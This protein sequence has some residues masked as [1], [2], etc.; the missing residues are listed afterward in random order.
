MSLKIS[1]TTKPELK[2]SNG[3][4]WYE[5]YENGIRNIELH[6]DGILS[7]EETATFKA[8]FLGSEGWRAKSKYESPYEILIQEDCNVYG[9]KEEGV[10]D[11]FD[12]KTREEDLADRLFLVFRKHAIP[13]DLCISAR[14]GLRGAARPSKNRGVAGGK[15]DVSRF[16]RKAK[17]TV[18]EGDS[19]RSIAEAH[20][21]TCDTLLDLNS[22][23]GEGELKPGDVIIVPD[24]GRVISVGDGT[25]AKYVSKDG[26]VSD[27]VEANMTMGGIAGY[28]PP[29]ARNPY[30]R[31]TAYTRD[32][33][34]LFQK[35]WPFLQEM[36]RYYRMM[37]P[38][39]Y[40]NQ[41]R[42]IEEH[43]LAE[44]GWVIP[45]TVFSTIT[46]NKNFQT[47][48]HQDKGDFKAGME[49]FAV[50]EDGVDEYD[51]GYT[52]FPKFRTA[53]DARTG[54]FVCMDVAHHWHGNV[55][56]V[57]RV[58]GKGDWE[59]ISLVLYV[60]EDMAGA[61]TQEQERAKYEAWREKHRNPTEQHEFRKEV[62]EK[63][64]AD[65]E[66]MGYDGR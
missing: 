59:R 27:T 51:G 6:G 35:S 56:M 10:F 7:D 60:R 21:T 2:E 26:I 57:D 30:V 43:H 33:W 16:G 4:K 11:L 41:Q 25:R 12:T 23:E 42:F 24:S 32:N 36:T 19:L 14:E 64:A 49:C 62:R 61:G 52:C 65:W 9:P 29:T 37:S 5:W 63:N 48:C 3:L 13:A 58:E 1:R 17:Y 47:A 20:E 45:D 46:V 40:A 39:R 28:F 34:E 44:K 15:V 66:M 55:E 31:A 38:I 22:F 53:F 50:L 18:T 8:E 54:D